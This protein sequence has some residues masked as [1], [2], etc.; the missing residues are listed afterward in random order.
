MGTVVVPLIC[1]E[2]QPSDSA[3][4]YSPP[5]SPLLPSL[6]S[7]P[8]NSNVVMFGGVDHAYYKGDLK[9]VPVTQACYW[10]MFMG[11]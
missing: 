4:H 9:W 1:G 6:F 3:W 5:T 2:A 10:H 11:Q 7:Q 8:E